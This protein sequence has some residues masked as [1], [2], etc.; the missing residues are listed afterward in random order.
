M[1]KI[2]IFLKIVLSYGMLHLLT[3]YVNYTAKKHLEIIFSCTS[4]FEGASINLHIIDP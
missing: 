2:S 4:E 1:L 3:L